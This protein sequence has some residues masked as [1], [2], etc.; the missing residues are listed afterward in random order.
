MNVNNKKNK[1]GE[2]T[3]EWPP[4]GCTISRVEP[5]LQIL[6]HERGWTMAISIAL[7]YTN[8]NKK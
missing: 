7:L 5:V 3:K 8:I 4:R 2:Q 1:N 6:T